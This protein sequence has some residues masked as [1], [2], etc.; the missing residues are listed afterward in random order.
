MSFELGGVGKSYNKQSIQDKIAEHKKAFAKEF[1]DVDFAGEDFL[2]KA[3]DF[4][5]GE[6]KSEFDQVKSKLDSAKEHRAQAL[7]DMGIPE[8]IINE[9]AK[10]VKDFIEENGIE[11]PK[12]GFGSI[13]GMRLG[14][15]KF[16]KDR[17]EGKAENKPEVA[18]SYTHKAEDA[19]KQFFAKDFGMEKAGEHKAGLPEFIAPPVPEL[20]EAPIEELDVIAPSIPDIIKVPTEELVD[21]VAPSV[22]ELINTSVEEVAAEVIAPAVEAVES[23]FVNEVAVDKDFSFNLGETNVPENANV[24]KESP[25]SVISYSYTFGDGNIAEEIKEKR[26]EWLQSYGIPDYL[27]YKDDEVVSIYA[28]KMGIELPEETITFEM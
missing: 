13:F 25:Q 12:K 21:A 8:D 22:P 3:M 27:S 19:V 24:E 4:E 10:A 18:H 28:N 26:S 16:G 14:F 2:A 5:L 23:P 9:G 11:K 1:Q 17:A 7:I 20:I 6:F 15:G